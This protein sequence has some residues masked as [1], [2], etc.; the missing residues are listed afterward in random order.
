MRSSGGF[1]LVELAVTIVVLAILSVIV[2]GGPAVFLVQSRDK[3]R[4]DDMFAI[5][6]QL[7]RA[8]TEQLT[9]KPSYPTPTQFATDIAGLSGT[10]KGAT[11]DIFIAPG[12]S[13]SSVVAATSTSLT[14]P[15]ATMTADK[16]VY[17]AFN[18]ASASAGLCGSSDT[19]VRYNLY[20]QSEQYST[21]IKIKSLHQQ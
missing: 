12:Q 10:M 3:E 18:S 13:S 7:E 1:T 19:C 8:Y 15:I 9:G 4:N 17:Q 20:Y 2:A 21:L 5:T 16:Y 11:A 6:R 14:A